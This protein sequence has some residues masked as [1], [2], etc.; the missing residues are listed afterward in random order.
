M[1][2]AARAARE[3]LTGLERLLELVQLGDVSE[4]GVLFRFQKFVEKKFSCFF[5]GNF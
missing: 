5:G 2:E 1:K 4:H 3:A